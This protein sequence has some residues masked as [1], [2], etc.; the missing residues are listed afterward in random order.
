MSSSCCYARAEGKDIFPVVIVKEEGFLTRLHQAGR[1]EKTIIVVAE[2]RQDLCNNIS[3]IN[4][5]TIKWRTNGHCRLHPQVL[6]FISQETPDVCIS[7][8][9]SCSWVTHNIPGET[10][11]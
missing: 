4:S 1:C 10:A 9:W 5:T 7:G 8:T 11:A 6:V 2:F 3:T